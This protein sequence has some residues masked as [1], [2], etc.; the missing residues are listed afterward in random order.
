MYRNSGGKIKGLATFISAVLMVISVIGGL[1][2][3]FA[4]D[5]GVIAGLTIALVG[6]L[7]AWLSGLMMAAFGELVENTYYIRQMME[8]GAV[9]APV[10]APAPVVQPV[11]QPVYA[12]TQPLY[13]EPAQPVYAAPQQPANVCPNCGSPR[14]GNSPFCGF[15]GTKF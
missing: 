9:S 2:V 8:N 3:M 14:K 6:C 15:C 13:S 1:I 10:A 4:G 12:E 5:A 7:S 11:Q